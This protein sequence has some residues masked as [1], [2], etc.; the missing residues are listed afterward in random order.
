MNETI[1]SRLEELLKAHAE[2]NPAREKVF[3]HSEFLQLVTQLNSHARMPYRS[4]TVE[5]SRKIKLKT[6][7][8]SELEKE[9]Y[10]ILV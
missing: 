4:V 6:F 1:K 10:K 8:V 9:G 3:T 2:A 7:L 5:R